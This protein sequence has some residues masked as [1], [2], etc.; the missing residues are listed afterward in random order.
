MSLLY[1]GY[2]EA[3]VECG[4]DSPLSREM[5]DAESLVNQL[6]KA[7]PERGLIVL[8]CKYSG[9]KKLL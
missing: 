1:W 7:M 8:F 9:R 2:W 6:I 4:C 3:L 5:K